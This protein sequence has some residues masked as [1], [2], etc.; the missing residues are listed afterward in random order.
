MVECGPVYCYSCLV[1]WLESCK[2]QKPTLNGDC[3]TCRC[4]LEMQPFP[5][6]H[7]HW[8]LENYVSLRMD[9][10]KCA[11]FLAK[12]KFESAE[13]AKLQNPWSDW[14]IR[15][16]IIHDYEDDVD[17]CGVCGYEL[18]DAVCGH[19][20]TAY[21]NHSARRGEELYIEPDSSDNDSCAGSLVD[22]VVQ[23]S[24]SGFLDE[25]KMHI[26]ANRQ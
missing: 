2:T 20:N 25:I 26:I 24:S 8:H 11:A 18:I 16:R 15:E 22:F 19:C 21:P 23:T 14:V 4:E 7:I 12:S 9:E 3:P 10:H 1:T 5:A 6:R 13:Y 17:R